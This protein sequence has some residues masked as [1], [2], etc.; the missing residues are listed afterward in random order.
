MSHFNLQVNTPCVDK[1]VIETQ[2]NVASKDKRVFI[3]VLDA[4]M[5]DI[6]A[7]ANFETEP[8]GR[9]VMALVKSLI[10]FIFLLKENWGVV[11][12]R[13]LKTVSYL[14]ARMSGALLE[15]V[16]LSWLVIGL[17]VVRAASL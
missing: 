2:L 16:L 4:S 10:S 12:P 9:Q 14:V 13:S 6:G 8:R 11:E 17:G 3:S 15:V 5:D 7:R 1:P